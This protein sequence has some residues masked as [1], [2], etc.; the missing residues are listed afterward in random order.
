[1]TVI[2]TF[3]ILCHSDDKQL[4]HIHMNHIHM[5]SQD[6]VTNRVTKY[7]CFIYI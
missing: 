7:S 6:S 2:I 5:N 3:F 1:M 4:H